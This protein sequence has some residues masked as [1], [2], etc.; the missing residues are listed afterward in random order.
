[1][2]YGGFAQFMAGMW[3]IAC[4]NTF[5]AFVLSSYGAFWVAFASVF[6]PGFGIMAAYDDPSMFTNALGHFLLGISD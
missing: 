1:L 6:I 3:E 5:G 2:A 4:G